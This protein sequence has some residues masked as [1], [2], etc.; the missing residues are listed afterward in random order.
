MLHI[1]LHNGASINYILDRL[2]RAIDGVYHAKGFREDDIDFSLLVLRISG[3]RL[4]HALHQV[5]GLPSVSLL[6]RHQTAKFKPSIGAYD[7]DTLW[8]NLSSMVLTV[9]QGEA[10]CWVLMIDEVA[11][12]QR[13]RWNAEDNML[14]GICREHG[15]GVSLSVDSVDDVQSVVDAIQCS[16]L[17]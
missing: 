17:H 14:Y 15:H 5:Y 13:V 8:K 2:Q 3:H 4:V 11:C 10:C 7:R 1:C 6:Y 9:D 16:P 12:E